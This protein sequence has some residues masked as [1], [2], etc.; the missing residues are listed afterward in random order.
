MKSIFLY[1]PIVL[2]WAAELALAADK[3]LPG[4]RGLLWGTALNEAQAQVEKMFSKE[5][6]LDTSLSDLPRIMVEDSLT[7]NA[8][9]YE[10]YFT[11]LTKRFAYVSIICKYCEISTIK[12][13]LVNKY[14]KPETEGESLIAWLFSDTKGGILLSREEELGL[15]IIYAN[16]KLREKAKAEIEEMKLRPYKEKGKDEL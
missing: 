4:D 15:M 1:L 10:F 12:A 3:S 16:T 8:A 7:G 13:I 6:H 11:P 9:E 2:L 14:G 5:A